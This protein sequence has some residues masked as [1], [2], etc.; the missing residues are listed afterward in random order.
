MELTKFNL[1]VEIIDLIST[2]EPESQGII[3]SHLFAYIYH[4]VE[5]AQDIDPR[6]RLIL[7]LI[8]DKIN[9]RIERAR[10]TQARKEARTETAEETAKETA[11]K[12]ADPGR[13]PV[14]DRILQN[15]CAT[16][17]RI[18]PFGR[19]LYEAQLKADGDAS[20][21]APDRARE[22]SPRLPAEH[23]AK[24]ARHHRNPKSGRK[25][26]SKCV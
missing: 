7:R 6:C 20:L 8:I 5:P 23:T 1:P 15:G 4:N 17:D 22:D 25:S 11:V 13:S 14:A 18:S 21:T 16:H 26:L 9:S 2:L 19:A 24:A 3:Y 10:K 12:P